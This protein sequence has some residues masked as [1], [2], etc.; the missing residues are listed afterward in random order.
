MYCYIINY[1]INSLY[2]ELE[3][4]QAIENHSFGLDLLKDETLI[5]STLTINSK[6]IHD[7]HN[8]AIKK[9]N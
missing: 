3:S 9:R 1:F 6:R 7:L 8:F 2:A 5:F 4:N